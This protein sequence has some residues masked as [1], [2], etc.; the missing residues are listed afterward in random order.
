MEGNLEGHHALEDLHQAHQEVLQ[1]Q[2]LLEDPQELAHLVAQV[3]GHL[4]QDL[5]EGH[6]EPVRHADH[7]ELHHLRADHHLV[8]QCQIQEALPEERRCRSANRLENQQSKLTL[9]CFQ[10]TR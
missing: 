1:E 3:G 2:V 4:E 7:Q 8:Q 10:M 5:H 9:T 6:Q